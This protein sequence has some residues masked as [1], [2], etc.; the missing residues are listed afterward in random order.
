MATTV[1]PR[2]KSAGIAGAKI[3]SKERLTTIT[4]RSATGQVIEKRD[5][6]ADTGRE[7]SAHGGESVRSRR[8]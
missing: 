1:F 8:S 6:R 2:L 3:V 5:V 7:K 4:K